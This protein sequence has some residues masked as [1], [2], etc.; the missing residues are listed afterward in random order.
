MRARGCVRAHTHRL[1]VWQVTRC[2]EH[3]SCL[4]EHEFLFFLNTN[5]VFSN[6]NFIFLNTNLS[7]IKRILV[8]EGYSSH[9][10]LTR[11][12]RHWHTELLK[13]VAHES[14]GS[15]SHGFFNAKE[16]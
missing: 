1:H 6:T 9:T 2:M 10:N 7:E 13:R 5:F 12:E 15:H 4:F 3:G 16:D 14:H 11:Y 8:L